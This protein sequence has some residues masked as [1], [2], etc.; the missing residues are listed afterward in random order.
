MTPHEIAI[1]TR[2][3]LEILRNGKEKFGNTFVSQLLEHQPDGSI[4]ISAPIT[5]SRIVYV[6]SHITIRL[7]FI[8]QLHG[9][10]SF[11]AL[12]MSRGSRGNVAVLIIKPNDDLEK[13]Q[14]RMHYRLD[15]ILTA[16]V[17]PVQDDNSGTCKDNGTS[18]EQPASDNSG[19]SENA[20][21][22]QIKAYTKNISGSGVCIICRENFPKNSMLNIE[23]NLTEDLKITAGCIV[24]RNQ[25]VEIKKTRSYEL[26]MRFTQISKKDE[27][28]LIRFIFEQQRLLLKKNNNL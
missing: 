4:V 13:I 1:G 20:E 23:L 17:R 7:T 27:E 26:G 11:T 15:I 2:L 18:D 14:R 22:P 19:V 28:A 10:L 24:V 25:S 16:F 21:V 3:E 5:G 12:V 9:L 6:P 8:H